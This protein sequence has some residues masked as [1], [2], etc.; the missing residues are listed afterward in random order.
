MC[1]LCCAMNVP[2][3][4]ENQPIKWYVVSVCRICF[5]VILFLEMII[6]SIQ[7][8]YTFKM[9][10]DGKF[11][12]RLFLGIMMLKL[13]CLTTPWKQMFHVNIHKHTHQRTKKKY[14]FS[15]FYKWSFWPLL[16]VILKYSLGFIHFCFFYYLQ[17]DLVVI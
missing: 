3:K 8:N 11:P 1:V 14:E 4:N 6:Y 15:F 13:R 2:R 7:K 16:F 5:F 17:W 10:Y 9:S 12:A